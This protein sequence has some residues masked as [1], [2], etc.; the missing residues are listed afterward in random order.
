MEVLLKELLPAS[1]A[2]SL[3]LGRQVAPETF[4]SV[5]V[6]FSD[7]VSFTKI[8]S[9]GSPMDVV[10]ML[11]MLYTVFDETSAQFDVYKLATIGDA[12]FVASG[13]P[14]RNGNRHA[15]EICSMAVELL[16]AVSQ[17]RVAHLPGESL[18]LRI[19]VHSGP[20]VAGITGHKMPR[21][22]L[23]GDTVD[24]ASKM[25]SEG[26]SMNIHVSESTAELLRTVGGFTLKYRGSLN[27]KGFGN[28][29]TYWLISELSMI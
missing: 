21:Y 8:A 27:F 2:N 13:V 24:L 9:Q 15:V 16:D 26:E 23:F 28:I 19:G 22:L 3:K 4:D 29:D 18:R 7:I 20:C 1:V 6:F 11:N 14:I 17:C 5:T 10:H 12:Y 25:E